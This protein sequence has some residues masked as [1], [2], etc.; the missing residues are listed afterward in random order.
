[1]RSDLAD[2]AAGQAAPAAQHPGLTVLVR[3][4]WQ[5]EAVL[6]WTADAGSAPLRRVVCDF[7][8]PRRYEAALERCRKSDL[9]CALATL[10][11]IKPREEG[12]LR[13]IAELRPE[14]LL[15]RNL[16][17]L[18]YFRERF[19]EARLLGDAALNV[20]NEFTAW[21]LIE[22]GCE[23][24]VPSFDLNGHQLE[25]LLHRFPSAWFEVV[26]HQRMPMF[27]MEHCVFAHTLSQG[28]D[29]RD[30]G[31]PCERHVVDLRDR[32]GQQHPL[33]PDVGCRNTLF[34]ATPQSA[35]EY[36]PRLISLGVREFR[37][38]LLR[39]S[40]DETVRL[41]EAY[42]KLLRGEHTG[43]AVWQQLRVVNHLGVTRGPLDFE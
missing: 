18:C 5:L 17:S 16:A 39:E 35:A 37:V 42:A 12:W 10:R 2:W 25:S 32:V 21:T 26:V 33:I 15:V 6:N 30:C 43:R 41:L 7:E 28:K 1:L 13:R 9:P 23:R 24:L 22:A 36:V 40:A 29:H 4:D 8:D 20:A 3:T 11:V 31:R 34:N 27:H 14:F 38:E 19:P